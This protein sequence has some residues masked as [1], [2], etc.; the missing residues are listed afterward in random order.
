MKHTDENSYV[1]SIPATSMSQKQWQLFFSTLQRW[2]EWSLDC[3]LTQISLLH[4]ELEPFMFLAGQ[5][6]DILR[7]T[8]Q[9]WVN[10]QAGRPEVL[11]SACSA[12]ETLP[13]NEL[14][15]AQN[16]FTMPSGLQI[17]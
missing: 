15:D 6:P 4:K 11:Q 1:V 8:L 13:A 9:L 10:V 2:S 3:E 14:E 5:E 7:E 12:I 17:S 16:H